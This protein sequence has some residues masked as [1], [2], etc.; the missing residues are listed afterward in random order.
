MLFC[1]LLKIRE[2]ERIEAISVFE[3][4]YRSIAKSLPRSECTNYYRTKARPIGAAITGSAETAADRM[5]DFPWSV[6][7]LVADVVICYGPFP[8]PSWKC[9]RTTSGVKVALYMATS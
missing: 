4:S 9:V 6:D 1:V 3:A 2:S 7:F 8:L 5:A